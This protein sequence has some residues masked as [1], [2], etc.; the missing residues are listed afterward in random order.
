[1]S[2]ALMLAVALSACGS[3][4]NDNA[5]AG[6]GG[7]NASASST[8]GSGAKVAF[9]TAGSIAAS[10]WDKGGYAAF[11]KL[12]STLGAKESHLELVGY[13]QAAQVLTRLARSGN[14]LII[15]HSSGYEPAVMEVAP[16][17]PKT[18][19]VIYSDLSTDNP[20]A[21]VAAWRLNWNEHG[22]LQGT[23]ACLASKAGK[24]GFIASAPI[25]AFT[26]MTAGF[27][28][29]TQEV[30]TCAGKPGAFSDS[31][32]GSFTDTTK[33]KQAALSLLA[34]GA[35]VLAD[36]ADAA[37]AGSLD[38]A[39]E[40]GALYAGGVGDQSKEAPKTVVSSVLINYE[41]AYDELATLFKDG[42]LEAK[43]YPSNIENGAISLATPF[44]NVADAAAVE[45]KAT[46]VVD[47]IKSGQ[48]KVDPTAQ[49]K[50]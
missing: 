31:W 23:I 36:G 8:P 21:N 49:V 27:K 10:R 33:G 19:F 17:F 32:T 50:P 2:T 45:A 5:K 37:G 41:Q 29:A 42:K 24:V 34:K 7:Q 18:W 47:Q 43:A 6:S 4:G 48:V 14:K 46:K 13:D 25:P 28:Q 39:R 3:S 35:D 22:Y 20:P 11:Q 15:T 40:K 16:K 12:V 1:M 30:G 9:V 26:R 38:A 44:Q